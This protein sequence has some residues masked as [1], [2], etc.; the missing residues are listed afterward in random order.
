MVFPKK[1]AAIAGGVAL[2]SSMAFGWSISG[3]VFST[4]DQPL[5][6]VDITSFNYAGMSTKSA[7]DGTFNLSNE[8]QSLQGSVISNSQVFLH[9]NILSIEGLNAQTVKVFAINALG[10]ITYQRT[11]Y[12]IFGSASFDLSKGQGTNVKFIRV[13]I[14]NTNTNYIVGGKGLLLKEGDPLPSF[15]FVKQ[16]YKSVAY[17]MSQEVETNVKVTMEQGANEPTSSNSVE[18]NSSVAPASSQNVT[19]VSSTTAVSSSSKQEEVVDCSGK[20]AT[21]GDKNMSINGR[22]YI[23]HVPS[24]YKGDK[25]VPLVVDYHPIMGSG[26]GQMGSTQY[27]SQT[28]PEGVISLYPDGSGD[29]WSGFMKPGWNVGP[30]CSAKDDVQFS[31]DM[32]KQV[33]EIACIDPKRIYATGFSMGGGMSNHVACFMSDVYAAVAPAGM[34]LNTVNSEKC[35]PERPIS[36]IMFRGTEDGTCKYDGGDSGFNDG[37]NFLGAKGN[38]KFWAEKNGCT[39][40]P[41]TNSNGCEEY[42][43]CKDGVKVVLC[44]NKSTNNHNGKGHDQGDGTV[45]WPFL[46]QF[47]LP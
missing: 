22:T 16:G 10:K 15:S 3:A 31:R 34:D 7:A 23:M 41:T 9:G 32:I 30:C 4:T 35:N 43:N 18:P 20:T 33:Q 14:D 13:S 45:G 17:K 47:T 19:P 21:P 29:G 11:L 5:S 40:N 38:F 42:S 2:S 24:A 44:T 46:K 1:I 39:G 25:P 28:D 12:N 37:L 6:D 27:K 26:E 8:G 36:I